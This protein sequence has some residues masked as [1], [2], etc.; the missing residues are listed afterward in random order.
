VSSIYIVI[1]AC[2]CVYMA[3]SDFYYHGGAVT[4]DVYLY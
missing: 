1:C 3:F 4:S 2:A